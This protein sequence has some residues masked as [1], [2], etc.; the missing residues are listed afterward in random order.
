MDKNARNNNKQQ[1]NKQSAKTHNNEHKKEKRWFQTIPSI[2]CFL[3]LLNPDAQK[4]RE[5]K[6]IISNKKASDPHSGM[7]FFGSTEKNEQMVLFWLLVGM[8]N[9]SKCH[10]VVDVLACGGSVAVVSIFR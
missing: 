5:R 9:A 2:V 3:Q 10:P 7:K 4:K 8:H 1:Q 6:K